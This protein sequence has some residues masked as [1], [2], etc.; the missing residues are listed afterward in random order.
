MSELV[1]KVVDD[2]HC[3]RLSW[4][5]KVLLV[6]PALLVGIVTGVLAS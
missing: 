1:T 3:G 4:R 2:L 6:I 5:V